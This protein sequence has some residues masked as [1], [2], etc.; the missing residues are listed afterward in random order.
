MKSPEYWRKREEKWQD[1]QIKDDKA[2]M[3]EIKKRLQYAQDEIQKE[4]DAQW[5]RFSNGQKI[6]IS[7]AM[8][9]S[10][11]MDIE[12]F[13][14][15]AKKYVE[16]KDFSDKANQELKLYNVTMRV[17]RLELLKA[18]IGL[19]L[20]ST[21][22]ELDTYFSNELSQTALAEFERQAGI[23]GL[24]VPKNGYADTI[25]QIVNGSFQTVDFPTFSDNLWQYQAEL[26]SD[27]DKLLVRSITQ[28]INPKQLAPQLK[29]LM[30]EQGRE[31]AR[32]NSQRLMITETSRVQMD[33]QK[34]SYGKADVTQYEYIAEPTACR[35]CASLDGKIFDV[36]DM[37]PGKNAN[38]MHPFCVLPDT[39][40]IA[41][42]IEAMTRSEYSGD[43]IEALLSDGTR[44]SVTP[45]HI[46]LTT[47]GWV[48]AKFLT[49]SD[50]VISYGGWN[51]ST[52]ETSS[53]PTDNYSVPTAEQLFASL[54]KTSGGST[55]SMPSTSV[56]FK[57]DIIPNSKVDIVFVNSE[58]RNKLD[59]FF[60]QCVS[61][62]LLIDACEINESILFS[63]RTLAEF[64]VCLGL[65]ADGIMGCFDVA[66]T[67]FSST[68]TH[69]ELTS[70]RIA[71]DYNARLDKTISDNRPANTN[72]FSNSIFTNAGSVKRNYT[73][74]IDGCSNRR[75]RNTFS[76]DNVSDLSL[77]DSVF[78]GNF[79][80]H[81][82]RLIQINDVV[83]IQT[84]YYSG[85][86]YDASSMSTLYIANGVITSNCKCSTA[87]Y[88]DDKAFYDDLLRRKVITPEEY[89]QAFDDRSE[90]DKAITELRKQRKGG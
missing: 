80:G 10:D 71:S 27:L 19:E 82:S 16:T 48:R 24:T 85:H 74:Y 78:F 77:S 4:I 83:D 52:I 20:I 84:R 30:T 53:N 61:D 37:Q 72:F 39:K 26:K 75:E 66:R 64:L 43:V 6:T 70:F 32:Y 5:Q 41:P 81:N 3:A 58:L 36:D 51:K 40:I 67:F 88:V 18:N 87:P 56:D 28:G 31:N 55:A 11:K 7:E 89:K 22:D 33:V 8:K 35:I 14:R 50:K 44:L 2:R 13:A 38:P 1:Q 59:T 34:D 73:R 57:G 21:F 25:K 29:K 17:N 60:R 86:V 47:R 90:A 54:V 62:V 63:N 46:V 23:L 15:K 76:S 45:N 79:F 69:H 9:R 68:L 49:Q 12:A 65:A 42:D